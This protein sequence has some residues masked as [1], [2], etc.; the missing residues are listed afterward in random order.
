[1][2]KITSISLPIGDTMNFLHLPMYPLQL[3][4]YIPFRFSRFLTVKKTNG[5]DSFFPPM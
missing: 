3:E 2:K 4:K 5:A 1:M